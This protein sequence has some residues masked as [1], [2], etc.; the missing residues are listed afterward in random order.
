MPD[1]EEKTIKTQITMKKEQ[2]LQTAKTQA[3]NIPVV[4]HLVCM[5]LKR[6]CSS[7]DA[8]K[9]KMTKAKCVFQQTCA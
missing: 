4:R 3:L 7:L 6:T 5:N 1:L 8:G 9:C 2:N